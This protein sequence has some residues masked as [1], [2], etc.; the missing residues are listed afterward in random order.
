MYE[1]VFRRV[2]FQ[3][4]TEHEEFLK[5]IISRQEAIN[6][7]SAWPLSVWLHS[8]ICPAGGDRLHDYSAD[9]FMVSVASLMF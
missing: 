2:V 9:R 7:C 5:T 8:V 1:N 6:K 3:L 4:Q